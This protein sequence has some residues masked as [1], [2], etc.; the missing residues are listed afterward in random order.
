[1]QAHNEQWWA[2]EGQEVAPALWEY[3]SQLDNIQGY[4]AEENYKFL[5]MYGNQN[6]DYLRTFAPAKAM[7]IAPSAALNRVTLNVVQSMVDTVVSKIAKNK[8]RPMVLTE[9]G[10]FSQQRRAKKLS[11]FIEGQ[12][13]A[14]EFYAKSAVAFMDSC[15]F[16]TGALKV[17][18]EDGEIK[19]DRVFIDELKVDDR[20]AMYG[21]P[22]N[23]AQEKWIHRE[24]LISMWPKDEMLIRA[25]TSPNNSTYTAFNPSSPDMVLVREAWHLPTKKG[26]GDGKHVISIQNHTLVDEEWDKMYFPFIFW[27]WGTRP[28]GFFGQGLA[29]QLQGLQ[30]E[31]NKILRTIQVSMHLVSVPKLFVEASSKIVSA[32][33]DNRIGSVIKYAGV[34]PTPGQ[35][36]TIPPELFAHLDRLYQR[37]FEIA[38][39]S[40]LSATSQKPAGLNSGKALREYNDLETERF[41]T[42]AQ[43]YEQ[44]FL[45]AVPIMVDLAKEIDE[46]Q[47]EEGGYKLKIKGKKFLETIKWKDVDMDE[48]QYS[49]AVFPA[50]A[51]SNTPAGRLA[52]VQELIQAG[53]MGKEDA[54][55]L[56]DFPDLQGFYNYANAGVENIDRAIERMVEDGE[57][58]TPEPYQNLA[59]GIERMQQAYLRYQNENAP[60]ERLEL[61]RRWMEDAR[62]L[63]ER[64]AVDGTRQGLEQQAQIEAMAA[65]Q[66]EQAMPAAAMQEAAAP[67]VDAPP[68]VEPEAL[69][70]PLM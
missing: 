58:T 3:L 54:M 23:L 68:Q 50:S 17:Y 37:A 32:H 30:L 14:S 27:R 16:G 55:K 44:C 8:P 41:M 2:K 45:D 21:A 1:M 67:D 63:L 57:Y 60:E 40:Q 4:R 31:I 49:M 33:L 66:M 48:D 34:A 56:L 15:I 38:G 9:A 28:L 64:A 65:Q 5:R 35:L 69:D 18:R 51:L 24:V 6:L 7:D 22:R 46:E 70:A 25:A 36:G 29:E 53:F 42:V 47:K 52:E 43:R 10:N 13:Y 62:G 61:L 19:V 26:A 20:E 39:I 11:Q 12:F 59:F